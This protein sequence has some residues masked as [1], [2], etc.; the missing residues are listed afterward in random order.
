MRRHEDA[1]L[2]AAVER[3]TVALAPVHVVDADGFSEPWAWDI[4][5]AHLALRR[6]V[7]LPDIQPGRRA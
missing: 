2:V 4:Y 6:A 5:V 1:E 3:L 7:G